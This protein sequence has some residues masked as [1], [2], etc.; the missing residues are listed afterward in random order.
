MID[1]QRRWVYDLKWI[2]RGLSILERDLEEHIGYQIGVAAHLLQNQLNQKFSEYGVTPAQFKVLF[3]LKEHI[4]L[5]QSDVQKK[6][7]IKPSTMN[8]IIESML[9]NNLIE[10]KDSLEDRRSKKISLT[11]KGERLEK[12]LWNTVEQLDEEESM[13]VFSTEEK[14]IFLACLKK[15]IRHYQVESR[16]LDE[17][18][19]TK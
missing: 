13:V 5:V 1:C 19:I 9:R 18:K 2:V 10:K 3:Q 6:L 16:V 14:Q 7:F 11:A 15:M 12:K 17:S 4:E 8:G